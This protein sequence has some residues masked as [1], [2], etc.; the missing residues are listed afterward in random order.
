MRA[1]ARRPVT[2]FATW[3]SLPQS[4]PS[5]LARLLWPLYWL[6][7]AD[8]R[9]RA[10]KLLEFSEVEA[11]G[12]RD[13]FRA[14]EVT[15]DPV[16]RRRFFAHAREE[17]T[18]ARLFR[19][20]GLALRAG[21]LAAGTPRDALDRLRP[22][23]HGFEDLRIGQQDAGALLAFIHLSESAA[24]RDFAACRSVLAGD[25]ETHALLS[26]IGRDEVTHMRY[27]LAELNRVAPGRARRLLWMARG[28]RL[29][30]AYLRFAMALAGMIAAV[31]LTLQ[32]FLIVPVFALLAKRGARRER[33]GW[34]DVRTGSGD[35]LSGE[36]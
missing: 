33:T 15:Q 22:G 11:E 36:Y 13:L 34:H 2:R 8:R 21:L 3:Q 1:N 4:R 24:A 18:H 27:S 31:V 35:T 17:Q 30:K 9:R 25:P 19:D 12:A 14:A 32:Y 6:I 5:L 10:R 23:D 26:R 29:W 28:R 20:R 16:L 7:W